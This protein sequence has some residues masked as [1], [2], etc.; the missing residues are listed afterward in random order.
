M[1]QGVRLHDQ[2]RAFLVEP[3]AAVSIPHLD[4][5]HWPIMLRDP[6]AIINLV[7]RTIYKHDASGT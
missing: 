7:Y 1:R 6:M 3:P 5:V 2:P 4:K